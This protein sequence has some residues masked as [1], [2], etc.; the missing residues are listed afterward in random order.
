MVCLFGEIN[1]RTRNI[2]RLNVLSI[3]GDDHRDHVR[4][5][6]ACGQVAVRFRWIT[7]EI[8]HPA[9]EHVL[10]SHRSGRS[11]ENARVTVENIGKI[12]AERRVINT[13]AGNIRKMSTRRWI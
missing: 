4:K 13:A 10:H 7:D 6:A 8:A 9:N 5:A 1:Y 11:V 3:A 12:I 2:G